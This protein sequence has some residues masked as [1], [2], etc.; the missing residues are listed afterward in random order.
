MKEVDNE[1]NSYF[2]VDYIEEE[3][4]ILEVKASIIE[5]EVAVNGE[6]KDFT[7]LDFM[8]Y[9]EKVNFTEDMG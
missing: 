9:L 5:E 6:I 4:G 8:I 1:I 2:E 7:S 3:V